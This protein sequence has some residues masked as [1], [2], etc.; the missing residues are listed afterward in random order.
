MSSG[1]N[2]RQLGKPRYMIDYLVVRLVHGCRQRDAE[3]RTNQDGSPWIT[4]DMTRDGSVV[5]IRGPSEKNKMEDVDWR[6]DTVF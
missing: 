2:A 1:A 5:T 6:Y 4:L 3:T